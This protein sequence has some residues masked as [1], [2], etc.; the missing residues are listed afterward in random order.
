GARSIN[1]LRSKDCAQAKRNSLHADLTKLAEG[2]SSAAFDSFLSRSR[3]CLVGLCTLNLVLEASRRWL[4]ADLAMSNK[5]EDR[6]A[7]YERHWEAM[8]LIEDFNRARYQAGRI[9][10]QD[11]LETVYARVDAELQWNRARAAKAKPSAASAP[12]WMAVE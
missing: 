7:A 9:A 11:Y 5:P 6:L 1:E 8:R 10:I 12:S 2:K 3:Q 4:S